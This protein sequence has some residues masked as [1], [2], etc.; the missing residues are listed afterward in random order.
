MEIAREKLFCLFGLLTNIGDSFLQLDEVVKRTRFAQ[1][2]QNKRNLPNQEE[3][4][5]R[6]QSSATVQEIHSSENKREFAGNSPKEGRMLVYA[7]I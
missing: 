2:L 4:R 6:S 1:F 7:F 3:V 5:S